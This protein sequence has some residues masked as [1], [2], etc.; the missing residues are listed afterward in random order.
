MQKNMVRLP[1]KITVITGVITLALLVVVISVNAD[2]FDSLE[3][4]EQSDVELLKYDKKN[5]KVESFDMTLDAQ[6][7]NIEDRDELDSLKKDIGEVFFEKGQQTRRGSGERTKDADNKK[8]QSVKTSVEVVN[9]SERDQQRKRRAQIFDVGQ[10]EQELLRLSSMLKGKINKEEWDEVALAAKQDKYVV[11]K[12]DWL[13]KISER[14]FGSGFYYSKIWSLNPHITNPH[15]IEPGMTLLFDSGDETALPSVAVEGFEAPRS[16]K[17]EAKKVAKNAGGFDYTEFGDSAEPPWIKERQR[18]IEQ[19]TFFQFASAET[20]Q[21]LAILGSENLNL[22][23]EKYRPPVH[24]ILLREPPISYDRNGFDR[25]SRISFS[26]K[27]GFF[28]N[29]FITSNI[30]QDYGEIDSFEKGS[31]FIS[32][33]DKIF[34]RFDRAIEVKP[35]DMFSVY[36][37]QGKVQHEVS[38]RV[39]FRYAITA[40]IQALRPVNNLWECQVTDISGLVQRKDRITLY[41]PKIGRV[42]RTF[43]KRTIEAAI[44]DS[45]NDIASG[46]SFGDV[47]YLDR[48]RADGVEIGTVF[49]V[50]GFHDR[51]TGKKI[52]ADPSYKV[53]EISVITLTDNFATAL[54]NHSSDILSLGSLAVTKTKKQAA[55]AS[56]VRSRHLLKDLKSAESMALDQLDVELNL[57]D[58]SEDMLKQADKVRLTE[59]ELAELER[60]EREKSVIKDH[61]RDLIELEKLEREIERTETKLREKKVDEDKLLEG[62]SLEALEKKVEAPAADALGSLEE[63][64]KELGMKY[65]DEELNSKENPYGLTEFDL[66]EIDHLLSKPN[67]KKTSGKAQAKTQ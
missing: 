23:Y 59:D 16:G 56:K 54:V 44:I 26:F 53:G 43:N 15:E 18:L 46:L 67:K 21:D 12:G 66:E 4:I 13:W 38:D 25:S 58:I 5:E 14:L 33:Y 30:V 17:A 29:T 62:E 65:L 45:Y 47:I 24:E 51:G 64:E 10:E 19:G 1:S 20:Y 55:M 31:L 2:E 37:A 40:Q 61:E 60:Q 32:K 9:L 49:E 3:L 6:G 42:I 41:T 22:E 35:G 52:S 50:Y 48:G 36:S 7:A 11:Q 28:L 34:V 39:G 27:E 63:I 8:E 57:D